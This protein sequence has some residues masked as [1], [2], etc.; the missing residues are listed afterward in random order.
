MSLVGSW[1]NIP[2]SD[3]LDE[4]Y[5]TLTLRKLEQKNQGDAEFLVVKGQF[6][7]EAPEK[8]AGQYYFETYFVGSKEDPTAEKAETWN[9]SFGVKQLKKLLIAT[10]TP[11][12]ATD[13]ATYE[14]AA[15]RVFVGFVTKKPDKNG[16]VRNNIS[17]YFPEGK[18]PVRGTSRPTTTQAASGAIGVK[19]MVSSEA[20]LHCSSCDVSV[21]RSQWA[22][23]QSDH[24]AASVADSQG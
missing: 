20:K 15:D 2:D 24:Q 4:G 21:P 14:A 3:L 6:R 10:G 19:P 9:R 12:Q 1:D 23:H 5:Y 17:G 7:V 11:K 8:F 22:S 18:A 13:E 16:I